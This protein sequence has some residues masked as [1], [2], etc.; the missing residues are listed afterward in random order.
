MLKNT[1][2]IQDVVNHDLSQISLLSMIY[3][4]FLRLEWFGGGLFKFL[5]V[6]HFLYR[7]PLSLSCYLTNSCE[8]KRD[9]CFLGSIYTKLKAA[10]EFEIWTR[11]ANFP[12]PRQYPLHYLHICALNKPLLILINLGRFIPNNYY[13]Y[14]NNYSLLWKHKT[15]KETF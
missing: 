6:F 4:E 9:W 13:N 3:L 7:L 8:E 11:L 12:F 10:D 14:D 1:I 15:T 2:S 5:W